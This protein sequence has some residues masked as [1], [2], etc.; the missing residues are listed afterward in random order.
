MNLELYRNHFLICR[1][2]RLGDVTISIPLAKT[3]KTFFPDSEVTY[4]IRKPV[5]DLFLNN[6]FIDRIV[7][8]EPQDSKLKS[9]FSLAGQL[10]SLHLTHAF[11]LIP[12][13]IINYALFL[14]G[15]PYRAGVGHKLYQFLTGTKSVYRRGYDKLQSEY[16]YAFDQLRK[17]GLNPLPSQPEIYL[18]KKEKEEVAALRE[19]LLGGK[20]YLVAVHSTHGKSAPNMPPA[21]YAKLIEL[22][23]SDQRISIL[24]T[25][26]NP[27]QEIKKIE[28]INFI[29]SDAGLRELILHLSAADWLISASTGPMH[30]AAACGI[31][32]LSLFCPLPT[33]SP[34]LWGT[35][36]ENANYLLPSEGYCSKVCGGDPHICDFSGNGGIDGKIAAEKLFDLL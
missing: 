18:N 10:K 28:G 8:F 15:V 3:L 31:K 1:P 30:V 33:C 13:E 11:M 20:K 2:D 24:S 23:K 36:G 5:S 35:G 17:V 22:L 21:E 34:E 7:Y 12:N 26:D 29:S 19:R 27:P 9:I 6:P 25:D 16:E 4:L 14:A 32:T